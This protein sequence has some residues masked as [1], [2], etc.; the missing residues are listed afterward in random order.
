MAELKVPVTL[1]D[2]IQG[3]IR[4][5]VVLVEYGDYECPHCGVAYPI[6]KSHKAEFGAS[7]C[8]RVPTFSLV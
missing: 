5:P 8:F 7:A 6:V 2:H 3:D 4:A 1:T